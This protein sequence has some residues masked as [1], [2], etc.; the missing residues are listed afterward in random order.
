MA[1]SGNKSSEFNTPAWLAVITLIGFI[2]W[3]VFSN[4]VPARAPSQG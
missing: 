4:F 3:F 2:T 1:E